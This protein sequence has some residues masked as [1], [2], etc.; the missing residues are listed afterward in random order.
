[1]ATGWRLLLARHLSGPALSTLPLPLLSECLRDQPITD[2]VAVAPDAAEH[3]SIPIRSTRRVCSPFIT[4]SV[5]QIGLVLGT[6]RQQGRG[7]VAVY[8][9]T[10]ELWVVCQHLLLSIDGDFDFLLLVHNSEHQLPKSLTDKLESDSSRWFRLS[11]PAQPEPAAESSLGP[12][13]LFENHLAAIVALILTSPSR[14]TIVDGPTGCG[15]STRIPAALLDGVQEAVVWVTQ[16][17]R[18]AA[19]SLAQRVNS[20]RGLDDVGYC[21][22]G[23]SS[24]RDDTRCL[25]M[26]PGVLLQRVRR[27]FLTSRMFHEQRVTH[28]ILDEVHERTIELD[29]LCCLLREVMCFNHKIRVV[30]MSATV[31]VS[32]FQ[33]YMYRGLRDAAGDSHRGPDTTKYR[34][35]PTDAHALDDV[36]FA[37]DAQNFVP[38]Y[39]LPVTQRPRTIRYIDS[40]VRKVYDGRDADAFGANLIKASSK[41]VLSAERLK[42]LV[43]FILSLHQSTPLDESILV[44]VSGLPTAD[45]VEKALK[46]ADG[47]SSFHIILFHSAL[48]GSTDTIHLNQ[49]APNQGMRKV[50]VATNIAESSLTIPD[51]DHVVDTCLV[52]EQRYNDVDRIVSLEERYCSKDSCEQRAG[53]TGRVRPGHVWR[54]CTKAEYDA[55]DASR[56]PGILQASL[57]TAVLFVAEAA[58]GS[59]MESVLLALPCPPHR[60]LIA[61]TVFHLAHAYRALRVEDGVATITTHG[62][63]LLS[64]E[65]DL[66]FANLILN[67]VKYGCVIPCVHA[68]AVLATQLPLLRDGALRHLIDFAPDLLKYFSERFVKFQSRRQISTRSNK[69]ESITQLKA[70]LFLLR[71]RSPFK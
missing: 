15:K 59:M 46:E 10:P 23:Q 55:F 29:L 28:I 44:F 54:L 51:I 35:I 64:L 2:A 9:A 56:T 58:M 33:V 67:G 11:V 62:T 53:R 30:M 61:P 32:H 40:M 37:S 31:S 6:W 12:S 41:P 52:K 60:A 3:P 16:P 18:V 49:R 65:V 7:P 5:A 8:F 22:S 17:R 25:F 57:H 66:Q 69:T 34:W 48:E 24:E 19:V 43:A 70:A 14:C 21:I 1:M 50:I 63:L 4:D 39:H 38:C 36:L 68:A 47:H 26:T 42:L 20:E 71:K 27:E 45:R 13:V